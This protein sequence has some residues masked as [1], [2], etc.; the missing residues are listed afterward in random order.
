MS[1]PPTVATRKEVHLESPAQSST[2]KTRG[3]ETNIDHRWRQETMTTPQQQ[4]TTTTIDGG[5]VEIKGETPVIEDDVLPSEGNVSLLWERTVAGHILTT[6]RRLKRQVHGQHMKMTTDI[7][8]NNI[9]Q[10]STMDNNNS[11]RK[12]TTDDKNFIF[13]HPYYIMINLVCG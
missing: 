12:Q 8:Q 4:S 6:T 9:Q 7:I 3:D 10:Q 2:V 5:D 11:W 1:E 13:L